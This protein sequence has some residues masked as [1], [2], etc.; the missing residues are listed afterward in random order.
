[1]FTVKKLHVIYFNNS[2][3]KGRKVKMCIRK[4]S[5]IVFVLGS[6]SSGANNVVNLIEEKI[7]DND[8][9]KIKVVM[10]R[11]AGLLDKI[12]K[13]Y[14]IGGII[15]MNQMRQYDPFDGRGM[16]VG[17]FSTGISTYINEECKKNEI[18]LLEIREN[19]E[20]D[21]SAD[22]QKNIIDWLQQQFIS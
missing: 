13:K 6:R 8:V 11:D 17:S 5:R 21:G 7:K 18:P 12:F 20:D 14:P 1:M 2:Q 16:F 9:K 19:F 3:K 22:Q 10:C 15:L 4:R